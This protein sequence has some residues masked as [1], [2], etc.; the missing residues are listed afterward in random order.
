VKLANLSHLFPVPRPFPAS[1]PGALSSVF[2]ISLQRFLLLNC[3]ILSVP[4]P[5]EVYMGQ[6]DLEK[7]T[8]NSSRVML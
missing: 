5:K 1:S 2:R 4:P 6:R 7:G 8:C 3:H